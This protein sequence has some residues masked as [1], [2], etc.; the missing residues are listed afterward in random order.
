MG[1]NN[2]STN[3]SVFIT[4]GCLLFHIIIVHYPMT[5]IKLGYGA[6][7]VWFILRF[8]T[9]CEKINVFGKMVET[10]ILALLL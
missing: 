2:T 3:W 4:L 8:L 6:L 5:E 9:R 1:R 7:F 10:R